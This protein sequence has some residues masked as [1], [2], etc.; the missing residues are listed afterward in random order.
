MHF[1]LN[2]LSGEKPSL[3]SRS[4]ENLAKFNWA[5]FLLYG[6]F[7]EKLQEEV[8]R[9]GREKVVKV[10][11]EIEQLSAILKRRTKFMNRLFNFGNRLNLVS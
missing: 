10:K 8:D 4:R 3:S 1:K 5:D 9:L 11:A 6:H 7:K 2:K